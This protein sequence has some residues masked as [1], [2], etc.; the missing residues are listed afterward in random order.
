MGKI[1][2]G[3]RGRGEEGYRGGGRE[4]LVITSAGSTHASCQAVLHQVFVHYKIRGSKLIIK[5]RDLCQMR[6]TFLPTLTS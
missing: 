6:R 2:E 4:A 1:P 3:W 5:P